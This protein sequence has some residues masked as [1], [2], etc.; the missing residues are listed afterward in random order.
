MR[1]I[2]RVK[3]ILKNITPLIRNYVIAL[4]V[5]RGRKNCAAMSHSTGISS[6]FLYD[7]LGQAPIV[8]PSI[9]EILKQLVAKPLSGMEKRAF[10]IDPTHIIKPYANRIEKLCY[11]RTGTTKR[12]EQCLVPIYAMVIDKFTTIPLTLKFWMQEKLTGKKRYRSKAQLTKELIVETRKNG[13][14]FDFIPLDGGFAVPEMFEFFS[15]SKEQFVMRIPKN[16]KIETLNGVSAQLKHHPALKL[17]RNQR[18]KVVMAKY[19]GDT[20][21]FI[22]HKRKTNDGGYETIYLISNMDLSPKQYVVAYDMRWPLEKVI[23]TTKQKFGAMQC[24]ALEI[25][26]QQAH[27]LAGFLAY[28]ILE[29]ANNDKELLSVDELVREIRDYYTGD[30]IKLIERTDNCK[31]QLK[32]YPI[33]KSVQ[34]RLPHH[35]KNADL[36][37]SL[38]C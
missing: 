32:L 37:V 5:S 28:A 17:H 24:Q 6:K 11:D 36:V 35:R 13:V 23:R 38:K 18:E 26:K 12:T 19:K 14:Q 7:F 34:K 29:T 21:F 15:Q 8:I 30:L 2:Q 22:A 20:F 16:R 9:E 33:A 31:C 1:A 27:I 4:I 10:A 3:K 25:E